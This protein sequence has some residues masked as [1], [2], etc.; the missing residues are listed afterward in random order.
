MKMIKLMRSRSIGLGAIILGSLGY[1]LPALA[2]WTSQ[3]V[4]LQP[5]WNAVFLEVQPE[6]KDC[7]SLFSN[8]P[9]DSVWG[10]NR[11]F[12]PVQFVQDAST[13][14]PAQPDWLVYL[15]TNSPAAAAVNL[16]TLEGGKCY[17]IKLATN[18]APVLWSIQGQPS[19][20]KV[21][22]LANSLNLVGFGL[23]RT[24]PPS[25]QAFFS[26][27]AAHANSPVYRLNTSGS[28]N[29]VVSPSATSMRSGEAFWVQ[30]NGASDYQG[31]LTLTVAQRTGLVYG[32]SLVEQT[33]TIQ[34]SSS[35]VK[36][37]V[38]SP[39]NSANPANSSSPALA[40][41]VPLSYWKLDQANNVAGWFPLSGPLSQPNLQPGQ[42]LQLRLEV[43]R[44]DMTP[45]TGTGPALYQS[46]LEIRD[47]AGSSRLVLPV[48]AAGLHANNSGLALVAHRPKD[49]GSTNAPAHAGLWV[50][51]VSLN[52]V[53]QPAS[54]NPAM[55]TNT[56]SAFQFRLI[57]HVD[58]TG[59]ARLLQKI[60]Q[61][62][63]PG[64]YKPDPNN[65]NVMVVDQPGRF[66]LLTDESLI[67]SIAGLTGAALRDDQPVGRR[68]STAAYGNRAPVLLS[69]SG[70]FGADQST[71]SCQTVLDYDD[72]INPFKHK[73]H[74]D[75][76][77]L[78][79][80][81]Q[82]KLPDGQES[83]TVTR[84]IQLQ[85]SPNDP[86]NLALAGWGDTQLG[87]KYTET[88][89]G[90][91]NQPLYISGTFRLQLS[92]GV[93]VLNDGI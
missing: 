25:F 40:G 65:T 93:T 32:R 12:S 64:T 77:N 46:L 4:S 15:P 41:A 55:P 19:L 54:A 35:S 81:F 69:G 10:W 60:L 66:V 30:C 42:S 75:H 59:Q 48:S 44:P 37:L 83:F 22:W 78:D 31:P 70:D 87:G 53:S 79:A 63:K 36:N 2:Q 26:G 18:S 52:Q 13:L 56:A 23:D 84:Q 88:I 91:H 74:P 68:L 24:N 5:G 16:F 21:Q 82:Q 14:I 61:M 20:R 57:V 67:S 76:D 71:F 73:Y 28:W 80:R 17:L 72:P 38:L 47:I 90:L 7:S 33:L 11:R 3:S 86:D 6:P 27:S 34:N 1:H 43:R 51:S 8:L 9:I 92:S 58:S 29:Q 62:W 50:G 85:F 49:G 89:T 39:L 45:Y